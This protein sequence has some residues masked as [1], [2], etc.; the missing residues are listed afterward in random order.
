LNLRR[1]DQ[2]GGYFY[3]GAREAWQA[4]CEALRI[5]RVTDNG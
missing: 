4:W 3:T 5:E 2:D 1:D